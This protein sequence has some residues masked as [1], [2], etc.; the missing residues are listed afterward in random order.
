M[1]ERDERDTNRAESPLKQAPDALVIDNSKLTKAE[2]RDL[3]RKWFDEKTRWNN[4]LRICYFLTKLVILHT[5][6]KRDV[7]QSG[8]EYSSGG[9]VV[10]GSNPVIPTKS[11]MQNI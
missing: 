9:R 6:W 3:L 8:L 11:K 5:N 7:A 10:A 4:R 2:Q 1:K